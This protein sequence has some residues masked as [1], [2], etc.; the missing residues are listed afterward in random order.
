MRSLPW[1][2]ASDR[3]LLRVLSATGARISEASV[4]HQGPPDDVTVGH[5]HSMRAA[6]LL[7][8]SGLDVVRTHCGFLARKF[9]TTSA[10]LHGHAAVAIRQETRE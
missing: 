7:E 10:A 3:L 4:K 2:R 9:R 6:D 8:P 1:Q 5:G